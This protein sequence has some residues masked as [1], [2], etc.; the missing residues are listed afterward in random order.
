[1]S[2]TRHE[3]KACGRKFL[4]HDGGDATPYRGSVFMVHAD[5]DNLFCTMRCAAVWAID[6]Y[7]QHYGGGAR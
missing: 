6:H 7:R 2:D 5:P 3:C 4:P 1:M